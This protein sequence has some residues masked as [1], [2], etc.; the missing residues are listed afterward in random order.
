MK[1]AAGAAPQ[2]SVLRTGTN[3][4]VSWS[5]SFPCYTLQF[6]PLL[7]SNSW[8]AYPGP[9]ATNNGKISV[10]NSAAITNRFF[11]LSF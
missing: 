2:L 10:T 7:A 8:S 6:A 5:N 9:F 11:R 3:V 1:V 4:V